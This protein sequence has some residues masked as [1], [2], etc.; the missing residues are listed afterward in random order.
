MGSDPI[1]ILIVDDDED[2]LIELERLL[3][4]EGYST[5]TAWSGQE[6]L[7]LSDRSRFDMLLIDEYLGDFDSDTLLAAL[8]AR[9]PTAFRLL[10]HNDRR[11]TPDLKRNHAAVCKWEHAELKAGIRR[12]FAA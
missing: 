7:A 5:A 10:M 12:C 1:K 2:V 11:S 8:Q 9:Q 3:E 6:A 4:S